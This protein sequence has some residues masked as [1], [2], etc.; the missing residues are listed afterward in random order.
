MTRSRAQAGFSLV[1]LMV[2]IAIIGVMAVIAIPSFIAIMPRIKLNGNAMILSNEIALAR[3]RAISKSNDF[4][5]VFDPAGESYT[6]WKYQGG[7]WLSLGTTK[8]NG[9]DLFSVAGLR[10]DITAC[11]SA[12]GSFITP[13]TLIVCANGQVNIGLNTQ[14]V[15]ELR[16]SDSMYRKQITIEPSGRMFVKRWSG[17]GWVQE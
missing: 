15:I 16:A 6:P 3:V 5:I 4:R 9:S 2:V 17:S 14:A 13:E 1:E 12:A 11:G 10:G 7:A 8:L